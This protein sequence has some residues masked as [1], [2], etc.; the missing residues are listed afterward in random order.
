MSIAWRPVVSPRVLRLPCHEETPHLAQR[1][2]H[3][4]HDA[5]RD[6]CGIRIANSLFLSQLD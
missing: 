3:D 4:T 2:S 1:F 5:V 6:S